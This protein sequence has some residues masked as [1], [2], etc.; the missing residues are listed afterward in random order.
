MK[1]LKRGRRDAEAI[2]HHFGLPHL[3]L[4]FAADDQNS[5][6]VQV[7]SDCEIDDET[8]IA[9]LTN[10]QLFQHSKLQNE[11]RIKCPEICAYFY[12][13]MLEIVI[14]EVIR[15]DIKK[16]QAR[17]EGGLFGIPIAFTS[18][19]QEQGKKTLQSHFLIWLKNFQ[20]Q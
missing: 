20:E 10:E 1:H 7:Y 13:C 3:F 16:E 17:S 19:T 15:W 5:F 11:L 8:P 6:M 12:E 9:S 2:Q 14:E 4:T 18:S